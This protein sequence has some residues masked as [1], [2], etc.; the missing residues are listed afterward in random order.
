MKIIFN[1]DTSRFESESGLTRVESLVA[2]RGTGAK[3]QLVLLRDGV[4]WIA[5]PLSQFRFIVKPHGKFDVS[6]TLALCDA[7][8]VDSTRKI[9]EGRINY[10]TEA[11][12]TLLKIADPDGENADTGS[13]TL[14]AEFS[15]R[16]TDSVPWGDRS[17]TVPF[18]LQNNL[19]RG[20]ETV[21]GAPVSE[22][23]T[24]PLLTLVTVAL[25]TGTVVNN[26]AT[27]N[28]LQDVTGLKFPVQAGKR[29]DFRFVIPYSAA[30]TATGSRW[31]INGPA[32][33]G[34]H[35]RITCSNGAAAEYV[36]YASAYNQ[37]A[38]ASTSSQTTGNVAIIEGQLTA[39]AD[40]EVIARFASEVAGSAITVQPGAR[41]SYMVLP[42]A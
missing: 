29:Y 2:K 21:P 6:D 38:A 39:V 17:D 16:E 31:A 41:V 23:S 4:P 34:M 37:P 27:A 3:I 28:T 22:G 20:T 11:L 14:D 7:W 42:T 26:N 13:M 1:T 12:N 35:L 40:G 18:I 30:A 8:T 25:A 9:Y 24:V 36:A 10:A 32:A 33:S 15:W 5:P 19:W